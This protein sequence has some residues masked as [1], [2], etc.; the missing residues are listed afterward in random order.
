MRNTGRFDGEMMQMPP[1]FS[2][3][4]LAAIRCQQWSPAKTR[5]RQPWAETSSPPVAHVLVISDWSCAV[6]AVAVDDD[7]DASLEA[8]AQTCRLFHSTFKRQRRMAAFDPCA[9]RIFK[10]SVL[11]EVI[12]NRGGASR[13]TP[14]APFT[15][16]D[17]WEQPQM[18]FLFVIS[19]ISLLGVNSPEQWKGWKRGEVCERD[20]RW[21]ASGVR[22]DQR[23]CVWG[24]SHAVWFTC[25]GR[26][27]EK[28]HFLWKTNAATKSVLMPSQHLAVVKL[29]WERT[30]KS[31][32]ER[33]CLI[34]SGRAAPNCADNHHLPRK[35]PS[36]IDVL[37][38]LSRCKTQ[39]YPF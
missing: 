12:S 21:N 39:I 26:T 3:L 8:A 4:V 35:T 15:F 32:T 33:T 16:S 19:W 11:N 1:L 30:P 38:V 22:C 5:K 2:A 14:R 20:G 34:Q 29:I 9:T 6:F 18:E 7:D 25:G 17:V 10:R 23:V 37:Y 24:W 27:G 13:C 28:Q 31:W 36:I